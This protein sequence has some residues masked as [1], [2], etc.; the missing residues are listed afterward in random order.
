MFDGFGRLHRR[1]CPDDEELTSGFD[2]GGN[3]RAAQGIK[4]GQ[5]FNDL[6][7]LDDDKFEQRAF[8]NYGGIISTG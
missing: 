7:C 3:L 6:T 2:A 4:Q 1:V 5:P 8:M